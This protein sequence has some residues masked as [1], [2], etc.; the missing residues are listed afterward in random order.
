MEQLF[1]YF[2]PNQYELNFSIA[3]NK[4]K[5]HGRAIVT[6][7][8]KAD[9]IKFHAVNLQ[10]VRLLVDGE[11]QRFR[12]TAEAIV[13][14]GVK[15]GKHQFDFDYDA[16]INQDM[17]GAYLSKYVHDGA[18]HQIVVT[19]FESHY[20]RQCFPCIDE[21]RAKAVFKL[22]ISSVQ[23]DTI[24][25]NMPAQ[26]SLVQDGRRTVEFVETP[27]MSTYL[28]AFATGEFVQYAKTSKHGVVITA[29]AGLHQSPNDLHHAVDF[30]SDV[31]DFYDDLFKTPYPLPKLDLLAVPDFEAGAMENWGLT[32]YREIA[33]LANQQSAL[34][35]QLY[36]DLVI[37]HELSHMWFG[38][39]VTMQWWDDLWL[40]ES[41]ANMIEN[42]A[43]AKLRPELPAWDE[44]YTTAV[45]SALRR[46]CLP[47]VQPVR[48][49]VADV[50]EIENLFDGTIVYSKGSRLLLMLMRTMGEP[51]FF[52]G[53][54]DYF[55]K[56]AYSN[57]VAD[58]LW[59]ALTP[60]ADFDVKKFMTPWLTQAGYPVVA[61][62]RQTR[63]LL[64]GKG[65]DY[66]Y[67]IRELKDDL[68]GHYLIQL[69]DEELDAKLRKFSRLDREQKLR[70]LIDRRLLA[71]T[72]R[73]KSA[74]L[75]PLLR[76]C[77]AETDPVIWEMI[78]VI[79]NDLKIFFDK[80]TPTERQFKDFVR[81]LV[82]ANY[83]RLGITAKSREPLADRRLRP[84]IMALMRYSGDRSFAERVLRHY[85]KIPPERIDPDLRSIVLTVLCREKP[86]LV[87][88]YF[89]LYQNSSDVA[90]KSDLMD[91][92]TL[93]KHSA[94]GTMFLQAIKDGMIRPQDRLIFFIRM[95]RNRNLRDQALDWFYHHWGWLKK[96]EGSKTAPDYPRYI[97]S[98]MVRPELAEQYRNFF[99]PFIKESAFARNIKVALAEIEANLALFA[100]D[101]AELCAVLADFA[102]KSPKNS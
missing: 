46:D 45:L 98:F 102:A 50:H 91:A 1:D 64:I 59:R 54:A 71:K 53:L 82:Y 61:G 25:A 20:A 62:Q 73:V 16:T 66:R 35:Q 9:T 26:F 70:L 21:P 65:E 95:L 92:M 43:V 27:R 88:R 39:L 52:A 19:Q 84:T 14:S 11:A 58:D 15:P 22:T 24:L 94:D 40:N 60:H 34:D 44:F 33:M 90:L 101:R 32:T 37:A 42:Y 8:A 38:D 30:A 28:L 87:S 55:K 89:A 12:Q 56:H 51:A 78:A 3:A 86:A 48:V 76:V 63:F 6:G 23:S 69:S 41:F 67:P 10:N 79:I 31:L 77:S 5:L 13:I 96:A 17:E 49:D 93:T 47:D 75:L 36:V 72:E 97:A 68:S 57:T 29:Y 7:T 2:A 85:A 81:E 80:N 74:S 18:E 4:Q 83:R 100:S 99:L